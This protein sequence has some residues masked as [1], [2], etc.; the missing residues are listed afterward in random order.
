ML[1]QPNY[2]YGPNTATVPATINFGEYMLQ[3]LSK[4]KDNTA[5]INAATEERLTY[6]EILQQSMNF[7]ISL[8]RMGV[9][10]GDTIGLI[11]EN[12]FEFWGVVI[13]AACAGAVV[14]PISV[15]YVKGEL[16]HVTNISKPKYIV[17]SPSLY[18]THAKTIATMKFVKKVIL[19]GGE[20]QNGTL[21]YNDMVLESNGCIK[22][23][24]YEEFRCVE[25]AGQTDT[26][27]VM[28]SSGT[29][30]LPKGV[31]ITHLNILTLICSRSV[32][33]PSTALISLS[34]WFHAM[35]FAGCLNGLSNGVCFIFLAK[36]EIDLYLRTI[37][38]YKVA[39][40]TVVPPILVA[41]CKD[42]T[43]K[44]D[45]SSVRFVISGAAPLR[46]D[47]IAAAHVKFPNLVMVMQG[48]GATELT[49]GVLGFFPDSLKLDKI[50]SVGVIVPNTVLKVADIETG[51]ALGPYQR[52]ELCVKGEMLMKGYLG[53]EKG[54]ELD[55]EGFYKTG[56]IA[57]YDDDGYFFIVDRQ[58]E[59]IKYK[60]YQV[61]PA[62]LE[63]VLLH[64]EGIRDAAV[65]GVEDKAAGE[66]PLA[67]VVRQPGSN[68]T[69]KEVKDF[70]AERLSNPKHLRGGVRFVEEIP[71]T[72]SGKIMR[73][74]LKKML[75]SKTKSKL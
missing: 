66:L 31:M 60:G 30:G 69:E 55:D 35:G 42:Q 70:V 74:K 13:G 43:K 16:L 67:F 56:D 50:G 26:M 38:K 1:R 29:T 65:I 51:K 24:K 28:Y 37:E 33:D 8:T 15:G 72:P 73:A 7:A 4:F 64:H 53:R 57:Y 54:D 62:E 11:S 39:Q 6:S 23:V 9:R 47:I 48:Y 21:S 52:G 10:K 22:N 14:S 49:L 32:A 2:I 34:P 20:K 63:G 19:F 12:R 36:F 5:L 59:L 41:I 68:V 3:Q 75:N 17:C 71:K 61:P 27:F 58:K 25:V 18:K 46:K 45:L 40:I 44:Y